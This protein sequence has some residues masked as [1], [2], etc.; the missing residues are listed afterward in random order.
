MSTTDARRAEAHRR[1]FHRVRSGDGG[2]R[3]SG[4]GFVGTSRRRPG[5]DVEAA[6][7]DDD[8]L[9]R[10]PSLTSLRRRYL[11]HRS[12]ANDH[13]QQPPVSDS[14]RRR[15]PTPTM[16]RLARK[17]AV[18]ETHFLSNE[19]ENLDPLDHDSTSICGLCPTVHEIGSA[20][21]TRRRRLW[22][23]E[24]SRRIVLR[25]PRTRPR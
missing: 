3:P 18:E 1:P 5:V 4:T 21:A 9:V 12:V 7:C 24:Y 23:T 15:R 11:K 25:Y 20:T 6:A 14:T 2:A 10:S 13:F 19:T 17:S 16:I 22:C 8:G